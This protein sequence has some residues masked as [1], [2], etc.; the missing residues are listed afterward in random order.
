MKLKGAIFDM[1]GT[2]IDSL[3]L[4]DILWADFGKRYGDGTPFVPDEVTDRYIRTVI[5]PEAMRFLHERCRIGG[6]AEEVFRVAD[7]CFINFYRTKVELKPGVREFLDSCAANGVKMCI[8]SAGEPHLIQA[9]FEHCDLGK[10]F[11]GV[12]SCA[13]VGKGKEAPDVFLAARER[14]GTPMDETWVFEDSVLALETAHKAGF[15]TVGIY[16]CHNHDPE[17]V[18]ALSTLY[19]AKG[20]GL[21]RLIGK[22]F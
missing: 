10:Y 9:V 6:S 19:I 13:S 7:D 11:S 20:E 15:H 8:A 21:D 16:D 2:L 12:V 17:R 4:W 14:L 3:G 5:L 18:R 1:D 22:E